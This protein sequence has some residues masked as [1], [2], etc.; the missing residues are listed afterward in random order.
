MVKYACNHTVN[1]YMGNEDDDSIVSGQCDS[2]PCNILVYETLRINMMY[3]ADHYPIR[4][5]LSLS[6]F[7]FCFTMPL[8]IFTDV[9][10][11]K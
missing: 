5:I 8:R 2:D 1:R 11:A 4:W 9:R 7:F 6:F 3:N 10:V